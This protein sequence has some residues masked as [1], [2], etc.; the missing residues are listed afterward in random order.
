MEAL[1]DPAGTIAELERKGGV[2]LESCRRH[3]GTETEL[4][5][6]AGQADEKERV[7]LIRRQA[8]EPRGVPGDKLVAA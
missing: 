6:G 1:Q 4:R 5:R 3:R 2:Q 8:R 7:S